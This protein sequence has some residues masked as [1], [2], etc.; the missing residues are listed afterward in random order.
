[1]QK[2]KC[3]VCASPLVFGGGLFGVACAAS[4]AHQK[5]IDDANTKGKYKVRLTTTP[6]SVVGT[7][8]FIAN[9]EPEHDAVG[10]IPKSSYPDYFRAQAVLTGA[11]TVLVRGRASSARRTSADSAPLN[12]DGTP[13]STSTRPPKTPEP[14]I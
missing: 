7:C 3:R 2:T 6:E 12:P 9:I 1:M 13:R 8:K 10:G 11:D 14:G 5:A 4:Q